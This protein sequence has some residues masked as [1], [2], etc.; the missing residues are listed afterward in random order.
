LD[1]N[2]AGSVNRTI[3]CD[4][5]LDL[6]ETRHRGEKRTLLRLDLTR[7][8]RTRASSPL[9]DAATHL[10]PFTLALV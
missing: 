5:S 3:A 9:S 2:H 10:L 7:F 1:P 6:R 4:G 8:D